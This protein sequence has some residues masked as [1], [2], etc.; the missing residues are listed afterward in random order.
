M[1]ANFRPRR[2]VDGLGDL[3]HF[4]RR[5]HAAAA[6]AA[7]DL[8]EALDLGAVLLRG[9]RQVGDVFHVVDAADGARAELGHARQ[10]VDLGRIAD[11]VGHQHVLDAAAGEDLGLGHL[12]AADAA[13]AAQFD[14]QLGHVHRFVHL[15]VHPV[16]HA[17][18]LGVVAHLLDVALQR[19]EVEDR[20]GVWISPSA[21]PGRAGMS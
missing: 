21:M 8:D 10:P 18:G 20:Q 12:L 4:W 1:P 14:L 5:R 19:V 2:G 7:V 9:R 16:A 3:H 13:G 17:M 15:A 6:R 11:L